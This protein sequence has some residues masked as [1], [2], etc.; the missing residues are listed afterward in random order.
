MRKLEFALMAVVLLFSGSGVTQSS[1]PPDCN[2]YNGEVK[3]TQGCSV[4]TPI[5]ITDT[6]KFMKGVNC[7]LRINNQSTI[8]RSIQN[9]EDALEYTDISESE[10]ITEGDLTAFL[11]KADKSIRNLTIYANDTVANASEVMNSIV[12]VF[13]PEEIVEGIDNTTVFCMITSP[14]QFGAL[15]ISDGRIIGVSISGK[16]VTHLTS[17]VVLTVHVTPVTDKQPRCAFYNFTS[18]AY[19]F[20]GCS[21]KWTKGDGIVYCSCYHL[22]YFAVLM[23]SPENVSSTD[24]KILTYITL[25]GCSL[26]LLFLV[27][28]VVL[29]FIK[30]SQKTSA[31]GDHSMQVHISLAGALILL[32][33]HFLVNDLA[34]KAPTA[35]IYVAVL[36]HYS[37]VATFTWTAIEGF[38][39][40]LLFLRVFNIYIR[41]Y[42]LKLSLVGWGVPA[43]VVILIFI[44]D[45]GVYMNVGSGNNSSGCYISNDIVKYVTVLGFFC[46]IFV[47]NLVMS[48]VVTRTIFLKRP[49]MPG[50]R[51]RKAKDIC[52]FL[53]IN[54]L[55]GI[56]WGL[57]FLSFG[58]GSTI[59]LYLFCIFNSLLGVFIFIW[60]CISKSAHS[61][62]QSNVS[63]HST[64]N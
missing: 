53:G 46:V 48:V 29:Y 50:Q 54:C 16:N 6:Q 39:L 25:I 63:T 14:Q 28:T 18:S 38:H 24:Q 32:N 22:T 7:S 64:N 23:M 49:E 34:T 58:K 36:L 51:K 21:T 9:L 10:S 13:L 44:I 45:K 11:H 30:C 55:L 33:G 15:N 52:T 1:L 40:Y 41:R 31:A 60:F 62:N 47:F 59:G 12:Q 37:M 4:N 3:N 26:S 2:E 20:T 42:L 19:E 35:C 8:M 56:S 27:I 17:P 61:E 57:I 5:N 43:V